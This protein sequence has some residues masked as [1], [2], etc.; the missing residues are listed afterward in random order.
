MTLAIARDARPPTA[1]GIADTDF[2]NAFIHPSGIMMA[3]RFQF[4]TGFADQEAPDTPRKTIQIRARDNQ[5]AAHT[6]HTRATSSG[7]INKAIKI[8]LK[9]NFAAR[10]KR[11]G[12]RQGL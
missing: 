11:L 8:A 3:G 1:L 6:V 9:Q 5:L 2:A 7:W 12:R 10:H 4:G